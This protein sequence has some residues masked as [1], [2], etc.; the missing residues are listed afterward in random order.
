[1]GDVETKEGDTLHRGTLY[2]I[3]VLLIPIK[4]KTF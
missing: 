2:Y 4:F 1:M 3:V